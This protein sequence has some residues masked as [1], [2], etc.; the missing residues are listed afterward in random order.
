M[1]P[2]VR[3]PACIR[4]GICYLHLSSVFFAV[5]FL[6]YK[7]TT[8]IL[9]VPPKVFKSP[10]WLRWCGMFD[11]C[12]RFLK[13]LNRF[14]CE[15]ISDAIFLHELIRKILWHCLFSS[16]MAFRNAFDWANCFTRFLTISMCS[17]ELL[18]LLLITQKR[19]R[20][21]FKAENFSQFD[22]KSG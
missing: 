21:S 12:N 17:V 2:R 9:E 13:L 3:P 8:E 5:K 20:R 10:A 22:N 19:F 6:R 11:P 15:L 7:I 4:P 1:F 18:I 16:S 14:C